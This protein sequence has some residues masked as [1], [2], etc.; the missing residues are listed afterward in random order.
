MRNLL[1]KIANLVAKL[2]HSSSIDCAV[3]KDEKVKITRETTYHKGY[4]RNRR[5]DKED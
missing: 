4:R 2:F 3:S 5:N 1:T